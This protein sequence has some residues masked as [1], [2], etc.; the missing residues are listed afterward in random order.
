LYVIHS[1]KKCG[2][3]EAWNGKTLHA[4]QALEGGVREVKRTLTA[5]VG[6]EPIT[7]YRPMKYHP[8]YQTDILSRI[9]HD[10]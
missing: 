1:S 10:R 7:I 4:T 9:G 3:D 5:R 2:E 8:T 6:Q